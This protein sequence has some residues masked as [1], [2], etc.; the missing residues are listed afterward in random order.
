MSFEIGHGTD[1][2]FYFCFLLYY[3]YIASF[4]PIIIIKDCGA[5]YFIFNKYTMTTNNDQ[6]IIF[7]STNHDDCI[8]KANVSI[9]QSNKKIIP[10]N[11]YTPE[12]F[13]NEINKII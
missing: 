9:V 10:I 1:F 12:T 8:R 6:N 2:K 7:Y 5:C 4:C 13:I 3:A 11:N